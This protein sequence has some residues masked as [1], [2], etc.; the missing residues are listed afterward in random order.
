M[1]LDNDLL[2]HQFYTGMDRELTEKEN[3]TIYKIATSEVGQTDGKIDMIY[4]TVVRI[5]NCNNFLKLSEF[6]KN[7]NCEMSEFKTVRVLF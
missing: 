6:I 2:Y 4:Y 3:A 5:L 1:Q 7:E